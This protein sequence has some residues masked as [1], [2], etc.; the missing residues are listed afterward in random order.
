M[1]G[2]AIGRLDSTLLDHAG[3]P[4][5]AFAL[6][7]M[8]AVFAGI[9]R[10]PMT[11]VLIIIE[12]TGG[13]SLI[14]PLMLANMTAYVLAR[15]FRP[16]PIYEALLEQDGV[17]LGSKRVTEEVEHVRL[18]QFTKSVQQMRTFRLGD[19]ADEVVNGRRLE[20]NQLVYP[21]VDAAGKIVGI[22]TPDE[23]AILSNEPDL[24]RLVNAAD[25]MRPTVSVDLDDDL[26]FALQTMISNGLSQLPI[27]D[28]SGRCVGFLTEGDIAK[29]YL[30]MQRP[31]SVPE[32]DNGGS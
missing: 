22:I 31:K 25:V 2:G 15:H 19:S 5:G 12:M 29:A 23:V 17:H 28:R 27:T 4:I 24:H 32:G 21:V 3:E 26:G 20:P 13:Y 16:V 11:S 14:L 18:E 6:V 7:G 30:G 10:A 1:L 8:G 9:I